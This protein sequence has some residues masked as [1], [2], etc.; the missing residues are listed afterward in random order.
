[1]VEMF[2]L[3]D[4]WVAGGSSGM[5][6]S[7]QQPCPPSPCHVQVV[8][9]TEECEISRESERQRVV[10]RLPGPAPGATI[11]FF[12]LIWLCVC[13]RDRE[14][15]SRDN[16]HCSHTNRGDTPRQGRWRREGLPPSCCVTVRWRGGCG[17]LL[18]HSPCPLH[19]PPADNCCQFSD[20]CCAAAAL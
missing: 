16:Y 19:P 3:H 17:L 9:T 12:I 4:G 11:L 5:V 2:A 13:C 8:F 18:L 7:T 15:L 14:Q 1:M 10:S 20:D 6:R